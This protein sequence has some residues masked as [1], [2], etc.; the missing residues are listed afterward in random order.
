MIALRK[1][2]SSYIDPQPKVNTLEIRSIE[3]DVQQNKEDIIDLRINDGHHDMQLNQM[4]NQISNM[5]TTL[6]GEIVKIDERLTIVEALGSG[7]QEEVGTIESDVN[8]IETE[9]T[10]IEV[11][12]NTLEADVSAIE[13]EVIAIEASVTTIDER[14]SKAEE[15]T[16]LC[17]YQVSM[18]FSAS[19][20]LDFERVYNEVDS[21]N[22]TLG[23]DGIFKAGIAGI[24]FVTLEATVGLED[25]HLYGYLDTSS[26]DYSDDAYFIHSRN[27]G[28]GNIR[29]QA[30]ASRYVKLGK[31]ET[32]NIRFEP[33]GT[34]AVWTVT[35]CVS[36]YSP[37]G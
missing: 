18:S 34:V 29:D 24:Y 28:G 16:A 33:S 26:G 37:S 36:L 10:N 14:L 4:L 17:G 15:R 11:H 22:G 3:D 35:M 5:N 13:T 9:V 8:I 1:V 7:L 32:L 12:V 31:D 2:V 30:S 6:H 27:S 20:T 23:V 21:T 19:T 25:S